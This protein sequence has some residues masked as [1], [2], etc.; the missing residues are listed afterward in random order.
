MEEVEKQAIKVEGKSE[1]KEVEGGEFEMVSLAESLA[2]PPSKTA[3]LGSADEAELAREAYSWP[4][5]VAPPMKRAGH[6]ILDTCYPDGQSTSPPALQLFSL[7]R[8]RTLADTPTG[9]IQRLTYA[10]SHSKQVYYD[11]R[12]S[13]WGDLFPHEPKSKL[14]RKRGV[15]KLFKEE[16]FGGFGLEDGDDPLVNMEHL[17]VGELESA[18]VPADAEGEEV[19]AWKSKPVPDGTM[20]QRRPFST[21]AR[22]PIHPC[23]CP[24]LAALKISF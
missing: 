16:G 12:K 22:R 8:V 6:V 21:T 2:T 19:I 13:A 5:I 18:S 10:K 3:N 24:C 14:V 15:R 11:A 7:M 20:G 4:R 9:N 23:E 1:L 17:P